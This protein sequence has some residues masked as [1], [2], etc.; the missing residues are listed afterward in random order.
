MKNFERDEVA[1]AKSRNESDNSKKED[2]MTEKMRGA[3]LHCNPEASLAF[4]KFVDKSRVD[5]ETE[6]SMLE[7]GK[8]GAFICLIWR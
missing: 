2:G 6:Q 8:V 4:L 7:T 1:V 3:S 5:L